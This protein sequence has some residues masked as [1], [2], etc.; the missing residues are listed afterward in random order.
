[1][2]SLSASLDP[3]HGSLTQHVIPIIICIGLF[4]LVELILNKLKPTPSSVF[5]IVEEYT[6]T[7]GQ[8]S[9]GPAL[10]LD[11]YGGNQGDMGTHY[12]AFKSVSTAYKFYKDHDGWKPKPEI[13]EF[14]ILTK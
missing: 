6:E 1:M 7:L 12:P 4:F 14:P 11:T 8:G 10:K 5:I 3:E 13:K 9:F 2:I